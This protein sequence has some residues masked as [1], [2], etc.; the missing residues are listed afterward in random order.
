YGAA[1]TCCRKWPSSANGRSQS[2]MLTRVYHNANEGINF[3]STSSDDYVV[4]WVEPANANLSMENVQPEMGGYGSVPTFVNQLEDHWQV[5][6]KVPPG[7]A[8]GWHEVILRGGNAES[9]PM[10][11]AVD[12][13]VS[14]PSLA[15]HG[16]ASALTFREASISRKDGLLTA[17]L[18][19]VPE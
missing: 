1:I 12:V 4:C 7:L 2:L 10:R 11:V 8:P 15:I 19:G 3:S 14:A 18:T 16:V 6:F 9:N 13:P 5:D 17:W